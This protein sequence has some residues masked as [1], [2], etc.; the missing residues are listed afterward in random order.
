MPF[1]PKCRYEYIDSVWECPDCGVRLVRKLEEEK[2]NQDTEEECAENIEDES[3]ANETKESAEVIEAD[4][5][6]SIEEESD[7]RIEKEYD[8]TTSYVRIRA[9][10]S[11]LDAQMVQEA[12][13]NEGIPATLEWYNLSV[14]ISVPEA[15]VEKAK[16]IADQIL[17][18][19]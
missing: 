16:E 2:S 12:L 10:P 1:C 3:T 15:D 14:T 4:S 7:D 13:T 6:K 19:I 9:Y 17:D 11:R 18:H 5:A 8:Q